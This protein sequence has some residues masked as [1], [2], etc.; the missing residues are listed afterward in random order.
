MNLRKTPIASAVALALMSAVY[1]AHAQQTDTSVTTEKAPASETGQSQKSTAKSAKKE[2]GATGASATQAGNAKPQSTEAP[3]QAGGRM[4]VAQATPAP[5]PISPPPQNAESLGSVNVTGIRQSVERSLETKRNSDNVVEVI[6]AE[7]IGKLPDKNVA[8][9]LQRLPGVTISSSAG[10]EGGFDEND[11]VSLRGT[12]PSL[13]QTLINGHS[14]AS[15][16][17]FVLDQVQLVGRS[18]SFTLLPSE[19]VSQVIVRKTAT[20]DL[21]EGGVAGAVDIIT[22]KPLDFRKQVTGEAAIQA[23][24]ADL[25]DKTDPQF[26]ATLNFKNDANTFGVMIQGFYEKRH[27][28]RDGQ[29]ILGYSTISP[30]SPFA[31]A[32]PDVAN[33]AYPT[34][35]GSAFFEQ[36]RER[37]GGL[38]DF[39]A[40][41][42]T[43][44]TLDFNAFYSKLKASNYNRNW[45]FWGSHVINGGAGEMPTSYTVNNGTLTSAVFPNLGSPGNN[46]QYA[47]VDQILR[48]N[49]YSD[50]SWY[51]FDASYR[52]SDR[53][54]FSGQVGYTKGNGKTPKQDVFEGDVFNTGA[55]YAMHGI[56]SGTDVA[57]P[58]GNP[59][60]FAGTT[61]D[62]IFGASPASTEDKETY[63]RLD[64]SYLL[65]M[66]PFTT[67]KGGI[68]YAEHQRNT[69]QVAQGPNGAL[70]P[71]DP[72]NLP[73]WN[74][75]TY[76]GNFGSGI[77]GN[78]PR[79][80]W[81]LDPGVL[82]AWGDTYSNRDPVTRRFWPGEFEIKERTPAV[83][84]MA[85]MDGTNWSGNIGL[86]YVQTKE[87]VLVNVAIPGS[88][89]PV[90]QPC[91]QV[92]GA[93]TTSAFGSF[94]QSP[95]EHTYNDLL[96]SMNLR[97]DLSKDLVG[98]FAVARTMARPDYSALGGS[99]TADDITLTG[100]GGNPN[101]KP[102]RSTNVDATLEWYYQPRALL[103][104]NVFYMDL[105]NY[106]G[107]GTHPQDLLNIRTGQFATYTISSPVNSSGKVKGFELA[108]QQELP[109]G[110]GI[111][112]NYT[113][114]D[115]KETGGHPLVGA[116]ENT[117]NIIGYW[118]R[119]GWSARLAYTFRSHFF[120]GLDRSTP[121]FQDDTDNL[122]ASVSYAF[123]DNFAITF[124]AL[125]L[126]DPTLK[127]YAA[128]TDQPRAFYKNG[129]QYYAGIRV[130]F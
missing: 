110:F 57:F 82:Q 88:E 19:I 106:V 66:G 123:N 73:A 1:P 16:D 68:R 75:Q 114:A 27:L 26:N 10:G 15:G 95:V 8:D 127:Y 25:P 63:G 52:A 20:A 50:T 42:T 89:C 97:W 61:L 87:R 111:Q 84:L 74:G 100:N 51:N 77:G 56:G 7:D 53:L 62:F 124:D 28:R 107:F 94:Y 36:E 58:S 54:T 126:N 115:A 33:A 22:R 48:P 21:V 67:L 44:L 91:P 4:V 31:T 34:L 81:M 14:V 86:R 80:P 125:N 105:T 70:N 55:S 46:H 59:S 35:I 17:W 47:I 122:A 45:M 118:E 71:F 117:Y 98:R 29:E 30:T 113:Y 41:P 3:S 6:T 120:V 83:Y 103:S 130:K 92:P 40:K 99:I 102:I 116:S 37:Q 43:D 12:S 11:R 128:N 2:T 104:A 121:E 5:A 32:H 9:A 49:A 79:Q 65:G 101:L 85:N 23:V 78:F 39:Q 64:A 18:V 69:Q 60:N 129:R 96:P 112:A 72:A 108:W 119:Y 93:I 38:I 109:L 13:T 90:Q 24:Y 76:P